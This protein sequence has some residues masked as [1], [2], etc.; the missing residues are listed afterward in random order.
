M[1]RLECIAE[2]CNAVIEAESEDEVMEEAAEH[3]SDKHPDLELDDATTKKIREN[4]L[5]I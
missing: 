5:T 1:K 3:A 2:G 4:I